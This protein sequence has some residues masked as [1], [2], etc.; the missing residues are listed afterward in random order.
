LS[1]DND[2]LLPEHG[3]LSRKAALGLEGQAEQVQQE[4]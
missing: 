2:H 1:K 4:K 3:I